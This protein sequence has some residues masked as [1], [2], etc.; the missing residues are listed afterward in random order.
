[1]TYEPKF[2]TYMTGL[3]GTHLPAS[4]L[5]HFIASEVTIKT[6][7]DKDTMLEIVSTEVSEGGFKGGEKM[8]DIRLLVKWDRKED[9]K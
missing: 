3:A 7:W 6:G 1:M 8:A 4:A 9:T 5:P 2:R